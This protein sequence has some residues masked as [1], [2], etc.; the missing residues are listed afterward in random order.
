M[1][2]IYLV[3]SPQFSSKAIEA[4]DLPK[5]KQSLCGGD[6]IQTREFRLSALISHLLRRTQVLLETTMN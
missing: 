5:D 2:I 4:D 1:R 3:Q 6:G